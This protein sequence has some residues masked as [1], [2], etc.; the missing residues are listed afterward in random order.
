VKYSLGDIVILKRTGEEGT[1]AS[2]INKEMLEVEVN[3]TTFPVYMD[4]V[5]HPYL[6]WFTEKKPVKKSTALPEVPVERIIERQKRLSRGIYLVFMPVY[7]T[8]NG[9]ELVDY[10]KIHLIN[11]TNIPIK[12]IYDAKMHQ[13]S[14]FKLEATLHEFGN[15]YL[16]NIKYEEMN[17]QP[18]FHWTLIDFANRDMEVAEGILR[19]KPSKLFEHI[20][21]L[22]TK[23]EPSFSYLLVEEF[24]PKKK[25]VV[26][27]TPMPV[28]TVSPEH[29]TKQNIEPAKPILDL[30]IEQWAANPS[31]LTNSEIILLQLNTLEKYLHLAI[32]HRLE[33]MIV[34]H[35][36][37]EGKLK[38]EVH[39]VL[40]ATKGVARYKNEWSGKY[41]FGAT[42]VTFKYL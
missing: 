18:R 21:L 28:T 38:D 13:K 26:P 1:V 14:N 17:D 37:G 31:K 30:H 36:I 41:G 7:A 9:E 5:D 6:K 27:D 22:Q 32:V 42:E 35:G 20:H 23:N 12:F 40:K 2:F 25:P 3:G 34:I 8:A 33:R 16:H 29:V 15:V 19:I 24:L 4:E 39:K 10:L 11:E